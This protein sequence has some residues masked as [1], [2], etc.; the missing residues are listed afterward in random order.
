MSYINGGM[1]I[2]ARQG[3]ILSGGPHAGSARLCMTNRMIYK[4]GPGGNNRESGPGIG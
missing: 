4:K 3:E 2:V 1:D